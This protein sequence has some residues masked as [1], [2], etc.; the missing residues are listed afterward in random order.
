MTDVMTFLMTY[1]RFLSL[2]IWL[3]A[4]NR[5]KLIDLMTNLFTAIVQ[6]S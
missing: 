2:N 4:T 1:V 3:S 5:H 6:S